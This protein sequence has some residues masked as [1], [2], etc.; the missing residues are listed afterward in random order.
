MAKTANTPKPKK[1]IPFRYDTFILEL[2]SRVG[3][4][5]TIIVACIYIFL[6]WGTVSQ[7]QEFIDSFL[8]LKILKND[9]HYVYFAVLCVIMFYL[10]TIFYFNSRLKLKEDRIKYLEADLVKC[11]K[12]KLPNN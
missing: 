12:L 9:P 8:L 11:E 6:K 7:K 3:I 2:L 4:I 5:G 1:S 10:V